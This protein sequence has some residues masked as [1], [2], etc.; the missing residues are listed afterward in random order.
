METG[1]RNLILQPEEQG[2]VE[3]ASGELTRKK[4]DIRLYTGWKEGRF[5]FQEQT[6]EEMMNTLSRWYD[7][8]VFYENPAVR[9]VTFSGNLKRSR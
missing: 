2:V 6:L 1:Q 9:K 8:Q 5:I 3:L 7:I 4:V